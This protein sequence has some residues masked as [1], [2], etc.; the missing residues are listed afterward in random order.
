MSEDE[1]RAAVQAAI[2]DGAKDLGSVM[3]KIMP[4]LKG[5]ADGKLINQ[6]AREGLAG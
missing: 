3:G 1:I 4:A 6:I 5:R 2:A